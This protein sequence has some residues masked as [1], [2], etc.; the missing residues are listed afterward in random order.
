MTDSKPSQQPDQHLSRPP[1]LWLRRSEQ[2]VIAA[3]LLFGL[4]TMMTYF[5]HRGGIQGRLI[6]IESVEPMQ[7]SFQVDIN[8]APWPELTLLPNIG[9][10]LAR[11]IV[12]HREQHGAF[13]SLD[14]LLDVE[15]IGPKTLENIRRFL[16]PPQTP[17]TLDDRTD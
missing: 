17:E 3:C 6:E 9:E 7:M 14:Q 5:V 11:R 8:H 16:L 10:T 2:A 4:L 1:G 13:T 12:A 15:G